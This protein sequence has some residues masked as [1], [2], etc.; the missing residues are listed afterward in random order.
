MPRK[1]ILIDSHN[2]SFPG[3]VASFSVRAHWVRNDFMP[4]F[5]AHSRFHFG[6]IKVTVG[7]R[8]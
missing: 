2:S 1:L 8:V 5:T 3:F 4:M 7:F 6:I